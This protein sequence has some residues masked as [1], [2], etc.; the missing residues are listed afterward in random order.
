MIQP[1]SILELQKQVLLRVCEDKIKFK[2]ELQKAFGW[3]SSNEL[4]QLRRWVKDNYG[5][6]HRDI[7]SEVFRPLKSSFESN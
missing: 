5:F 1:Q 6:T 2:K 7:I 3:L 4:I